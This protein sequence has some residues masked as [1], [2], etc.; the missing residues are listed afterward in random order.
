MLDES[1]EKCGSRAR[2][3]GFAIPVGTTS[4]RL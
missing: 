2:R 1:Y 4:G 3:N